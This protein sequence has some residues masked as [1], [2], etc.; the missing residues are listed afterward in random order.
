MQD[1]QNVLGNVQNIHEHVQVIPERDIRVRHRRRRRVEPPRPKQKVWCEENT[2]LLLLIIASL[3]F[4]LLGLVTGS[5]VVSVWWVNGTDY[6]NLKFENI[7]LK[8]FVNLNLSYCSRD[9]N[10]CEGEFNN[11]ASLYHE[12]KKTAE[13]QKNGW[14]KCEL[15]K[16]KVEAELKVSKNT[17]LFIEHDT[18]KNCTNTV[19]MYKDSMTSIEKQLQKCQ[20]KLKNCCSSWYFKC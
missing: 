5:V 19:Q 10:K 9:L 3:V 18:R 7:Q 16:C 13:Q 8:E 1:V 12:M 11:Y 2:Q 6:E 17:P 20:E 15:E 4:F 14:N